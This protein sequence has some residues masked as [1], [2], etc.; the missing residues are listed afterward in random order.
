[1]RW[2][3][4]FPCTFPDWLALRWEGADLNASGSPSMT[5]SKSGAPA[6]FE[7]RMDWLKTALNS[8]KYAAAVVS[9][10]C[11]D[12]VHLDTELRRTVAANGE[13]LM[14][15][16]PRSLY[17][18]GR[19]RSLLKVKLF[20]DEEGRVTGYEVCYCWVCF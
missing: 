19:D 16:R 12:A 15:R 6:E 10:E 3:L 4:S 7:A 1:M 9:V 2:Y 8:C 17:A 5:D 14:I 11:R 18:H 20:H 13:G